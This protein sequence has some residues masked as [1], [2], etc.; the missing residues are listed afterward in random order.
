MDDRLDVLLYKASSNFG[1]DEAAG[2][3]A[4]AFVKSL[5]QRTAYREYFMS[6][7]LLIPVHKV[8]SSTNCSKIA[9]ANRISV[10][11]LGA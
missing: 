11:W 2:W 1:N 3:K 6:V 7:L 5:L 4:L 9:S 10:E 8:I